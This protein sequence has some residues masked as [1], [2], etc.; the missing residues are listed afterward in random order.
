M[1][2]DIFCDMDGVL[3][4]FYDGVI[5]ATGKHIDKVRGEERN[6][7]VKKI[8]DTGEQ[9]WINL[10]PLPDYLELWN[11]IKPYNPYILTACPHKNGRERGIL[12]QNVVRY[13]HDGKLAWVNKYTPV[14]Q[15]HFLVVDREHKS[16]YATSIKHGQVLSNILIDDTEQNIKEWRRN[17]GIGILHKNA[18]SSVIEL[19]K[20]GYGS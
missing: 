8:F 9:F 11:F 7:L 3:V 17:R 6:A 13:A 15:S 1:F 5:L 10:K 14:P 20:L 12:S 18:L 2:G 16:N 4:N 19:R